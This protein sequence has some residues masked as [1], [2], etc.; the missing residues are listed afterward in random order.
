MTKKNYE[1]FKVFE[2]TCGKKFVPTYGWVYKKQKGKY[3]KYFC[4][5]SCWRKAGGG[6]GKTFYA[7][8]YR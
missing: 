8:R 2:C 1:P 7:K 5:Y 6:N 4:S 3:F